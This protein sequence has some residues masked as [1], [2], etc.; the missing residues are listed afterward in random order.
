M[1]FYKI[2]IASKHL[3]LDLH[4]FMAFFIFFYLD[5]LLP[6]DILCFKVFINMQ[7]FICALCWEHC[8]ALSRSRQQSFQSHQEEKHQESYS[9][10]GT[11]P[12]SSEKKNSA[13]FML[14]DC[15]KGN[16]A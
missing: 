1:G 12:P 8:K 16:F 4:N 3:H 15:H 14:K 2:F 9:L 6:E 13:I 5:V 10:N 7:S 11:G